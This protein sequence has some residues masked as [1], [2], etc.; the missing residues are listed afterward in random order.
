[1]GCSF[2]WLAGKTPCLITPAKVLIPLLVKGDIPYLDHDTW[3]KYVDASV[4]DLRQPIGAVIANG[5]LIATTDVKF[6]PAPACAA[7]S[8]V[9]PNTEDNIPWEWCKEV[10]DR[11]VGCKLT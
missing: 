9:L 10:E 2:V 5:E 11:S 1:M 4:K 7:P 3:M 6:K 8:P